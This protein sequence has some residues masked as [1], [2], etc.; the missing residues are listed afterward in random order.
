ME[1][2]PRS[3]SRTVVWLLTVTLTGAVLMGLEMVAFRLYAPYFGYSTYVWGS[4]ISVVM[5]A[6]SCGYALGG[7]AADRSRD[8]APLYGA[9]LFSALYQLLVIYAA[10]RL[11]PALARLGEFTGKKS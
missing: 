2:G 10:G 8:D 11:L 7:R 1:P 5:L 9:M 3:R 6:M 4:M